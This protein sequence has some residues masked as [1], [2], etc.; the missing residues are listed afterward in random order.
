MVGPFLATARQVPKTEINIQ[1]SG[2]TEVNIRHSLV[3]AHNAKISHSD[4]VEM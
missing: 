2:A 3:I 4:I 1:P